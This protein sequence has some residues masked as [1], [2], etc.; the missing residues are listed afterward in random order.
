MNGRIA[1]I[2][3]YSVLNLALIFFYQPFHARTQYEPFH[4]KGK[5]SKSTHEIFTLLGRPDIVELKA[6]HEFA[7]KNLLRSGERWNVQTEKPVH[8]AMHN[9]RPALITCLQNIG[10]IDARK[11]QEKHH[12]YAGL[13]GALKERVNLRMNYLTKLID[14]GYTFDYIVLMGGRRPL[15]DQEKVGLPENVTTEAEMMIYLVQNSQ[16]KDHNILVVDVPMVKREDGTFVRPTTD[17]TFIHFAH[18]APHNGPF[19]V[20]S[21]NPYIL[22]QTLV[23]WRLLD[24]TKFPVEGAGPLADADELDIIMICDEFART[25]YEFYKQEQKNLAS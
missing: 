25:L 22:R 23:A 16:L 1:L 18:T 9:N 5:L 10:M 7:Q 11:P 4:T 2:T 15:Q 8:M 20:I 13:L 14:E 19:L 12:I 21:N 17:D 3:A 24:Q 6:A